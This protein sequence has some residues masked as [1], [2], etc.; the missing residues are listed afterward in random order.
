MIAI[1]GDNCD[2]WLLLHKYPEAEFISYH[3]T[4][5]GIDAVPVVSVSG[6]AAQWIGAIA[7]SLIA[8]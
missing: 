5:A 6:P 2:I 8:R 1:P 7:V 3:I 4:A